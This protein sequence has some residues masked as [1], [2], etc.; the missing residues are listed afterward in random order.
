MLLLFFFGENPQP[1]ILG[2]AGFNAEEVYGLGS[3]GFKGL[4]YQGLGCLQAFRALGL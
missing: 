4:G 2:P 3:E 1:G